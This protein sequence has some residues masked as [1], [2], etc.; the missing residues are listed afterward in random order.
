[1]LSLI[2]KVYLSALILEELIAT[3]GVD[4]EQA[5]EVYVKFDRETL[6]STK[7]GKNIKN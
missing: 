3:G 6:K 5:S 4:K 1:M 2:Q 7:A